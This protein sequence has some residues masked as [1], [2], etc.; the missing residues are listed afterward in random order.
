[1]VQEVETDDRSP[2][3][4]T[5][6]ERVEYYQRRENEEER[7]RREEEELLKRHS[8][9]KQPVDTLRRNTPVG[10]NTS[11]SSPSS[12]DENL[13]PSDAVPHLVS[14]FERDAAGNTIVQ[15]KHHRPT[16][17]RQHETRT[18]DQGTRF[19][20]PIRQDEKRHLE[21]EMGIE[22]DESEETSEESHV[23]NEMVHDTE[24][25]LS[26]RADSL[27][28]HFQKVD[29]ELQIAEQHSAESSSS[30]SSTSQERNRSLQT[31]G[32]ELEMAERSFSRDE[33]L[34]EGNQTA[35]ENELQLQ[36]AE[37]TRA[38][39]AE[40]DIMPSR[41]SRAGERPSGV[42]LPE[43]AK[44]GS[45]VVRSFS[46]P[47]VPQQRSKSAEADSKYSSNDDDIPREIV[48]KEASFELP[49]EV[50]GD[51]V[52]LSPKIADLNMS[53][54]IPPS[55]LGGSWSGLLAGKSSFGNPNTVCGSAS[56]EYRVSRWIRLS[57]GFTRGFEVKQN[58]ISLG[59]RLL[60]KGGSTL[61]VTFYHQPSI[62]ENATKLHLWSWSMTFR[63]CFEQ[64]KWALSSVLSRRRDVSLVLTNNKL[65]A[66]VGWKLQSAKQV[67]VRV[68]ARPRL[69]E[70]RKAHLYCQWRSGIW[71]FGASLVQSL[72]SRVATVGIGWRV[73]STRGLEWVVSWNRGNAT[74]NIPITLS[75][76]L[77]NASAAE[78]M[79]LSLVSY[80]VQDCIAEMWG[81]IGEK[82]V[83][84]DESGSVQ[85]SP[86]V[87]QLATNFVASGDKFCS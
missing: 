81:W 30:S 49:L 10:E 21:Q 83:E 36:S 60:R 78:A 31:L 12:Y 7:R 72:H 77:T 79:Y 38:M 70:Y 25:H 65:S 28:R 15:L 3:N 57:M 68:D 5:V 56:L 32:S 42:G 51:G 40:D 86:Q 18:F 85:T 55:R 17:T 11:E 27:E 20:P 8:P 46:I 37:R 58:L 13:L 4:G 64:S 39:M 80:F 34:V 53:T 74:I 29:R 44:K 73:Y 61:G 6:K 2:S 22:R 69:S 67:L 62:L 50:T 35:L 48:H 76:H 24:R 1:M 47:P 52:K 33:P 16:L 54:T 87:L 71:Q 75:K 41:D 82:A 66:R 63:H 45:L 19:G 14:E 43:R 23:V 26:E 84:G 59:S 9:P